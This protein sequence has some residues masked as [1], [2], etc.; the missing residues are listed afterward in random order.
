MNTIHKT[1]PFR[2]IRVTCIENSVSSVRNDRL[3]MLL[4]KSIHLEGPDSDL[5]VGRTYDVQAIEVRGDAGWW[6]YLHTVSSSDWP[7]PYPAEFFTIDENT[8]PEDWCI[9]S[10]FQ[11]GRFALKCISFAE[12]ASD[13]SFYE[14]LID[15][16]SMALAVYRQH[17]R[18]HPER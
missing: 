13:N 4:Q 18:G 12:W 8:L 3:R 7:Y 2:G 6:L 14:K 10:Q 16:D 1:T 15:G 5:E 11:E 17:L 9:G